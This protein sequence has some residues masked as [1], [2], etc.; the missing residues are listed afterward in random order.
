[1]L[2]KNR[3]LIFIP[4]LLILLKSSF[5]LA[6]V[7]MSEEIKNRILSV[8]HSIL[9][10]N[11]DQLYSDL[12]DGILDVSLYYGPIKYSNSWH[13]S[14]KYAI[15]SKIDLKNKFDI[16]F[17]QSFKES[18]SKFGIKDFV[19]NQSWWGLQWEWGDGPYEMIFNEQDG[20]L[21]MVKNGTAVMPSFNCAK[22]SNRVEKSIC[23]DKSLADKDRELSSKY[24]YARGVLTGLEAKKMKSNQLTFIKKRN[25]L[26]I[27]VNDDSELR[28]LILRS[29]DNRIKE[30][31]TLIEKESNKPTILVPLKEG[32]KLIQGQWSITDFERASNL[33]SGSHDDY[34]NAF[35]SSSYTVFVKN[36][37]IIVTKSTKKRVLENTTSLDAYGVYIKDYLRDTDSDT[38]CKIIEV[39]QLSL[40]KWFD[41]EA[42]HPGRYGTGG[43]YIGKFD[44]LP[45]VYVF[46][47][48]PNC[49]LI[50]EF[51]YF[52]YTQ[53]H[54]GEGKA[55]LADMI[56]AEDETNQNDVSIDKLLPDHMFF[57]KNE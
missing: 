8:K 9:T 12:E 31:S 51:S 10:K 53:N 26:A 47:L 35:V 19:F 23:K 29:M 15:K 54:K 3:I 11:I 55:Y 20:S 18:I 7:E 46:K 52:I 1:M 56:E 21:L 36:D 6:D 43:G 33:S 40:A 57:L 39:F 38:V 13:G 28:K 27:D 32:L 37:K 48:D 49:P 17:N 41:L 4:I 2:S 25:S 16:I 30:L 5:A 14:S 50:E 44:M 45:D 24:F 22:A 42:N 34:L